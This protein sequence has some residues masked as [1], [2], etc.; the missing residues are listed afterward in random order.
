[1][2]GRISLAT[3]LHLKTNEPPEDRALSLT[4]ILADAINLGLAKMAEVCPSFAKPARV[5]AWYIRDETY[6]KTL[7]KLV[8]F[9]HRI[10]F[11][12]HRGEGTTFSSDG[13]R[14]RAGGR[15]GPA[16]TKARY[17]SDPSVTFYTHIS[18]RFAPFHLFTP[19]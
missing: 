6:S 18:D 4:A 8:N 13:H 3:F 19:R 2:P 11:A 16:Q 1:M 14:N 12:A 15:R 17:V 7:A 10:P 5:V 9:A